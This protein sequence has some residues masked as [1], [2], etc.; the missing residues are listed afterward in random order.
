MQLV[1][2]PFRNNTPGFLGIRDYLGGGFKDLLFLSRTLGKM[3][4]F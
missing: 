4:P 3:N 1:K 2:I